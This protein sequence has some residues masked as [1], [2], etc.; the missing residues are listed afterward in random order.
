MV[1]SMVAYGSWESNLGDFSVVQPS[2]SLLQVLAK[3]VI[4]CM[5]HVACNQLEKNGK[6]PTSDL[7]SIQSTAVPTWRVKWN[8]ICQDQSSFQTFSRNWLSGWDMFNPWIYD[9]LQNPSSDIQYIIDFERRTANLSASFFCFELGRA[10]M[11]PGVSTKTKPELLSSSQQNLDFNRF[12]KAL[13]N[14]ALHVNQISNPAEPV[15][16]FRPN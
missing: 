11:A 6:M 15:R 2:S 7:W 3:V 4:G 5:L 9:Q 8:C 13:Q 16:L 1:G 10:F 12:L 14:P